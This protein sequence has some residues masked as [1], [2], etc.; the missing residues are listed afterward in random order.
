MTQKQFIGSE[1]Q[2][3]YNE[4]KVVIL[5]IPYEKTTT[6]R[7]GCQN[8]AAAIIEASDQLEAYDIELGREICQEMGIFTH[9]AI[10]DTRINP[11][12]TPEA[13]IEITT[14]TVSKLIADRKFV[15][16]LGGEHSI[17]GAVVKAYKQALG[18]E[19]FT[20]IQI[21]AHGDMRHSYE[22]SIYNHACVMR[23]VL[24]MGLPTL[25]IGIR[26]ICQE[27]AQLI[28]EKQIPVIWAT[29]IYRQSNWS[30]RALSQITT[31]KVFITIDLDGLDP[32]LMPGVGTPEPGGL[33][34]YELT[35]FLTRVFAEYQ[36]IGC[37]VMELAPSSDSVVSEF[38]AA[39]L[40]Y[41]LIGYQSNF[42]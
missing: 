22:G 31:K 36:V 34:W 39:K 4:A 14:N 37:D 30:D 27:E 8:G 29:D 15:I 42:A 26:S 12:L 40:V 38:T 13:M 18:E 23:R 35:Q 41:K 7:K 6:Y 24:D 33:N 5:P 16:A 20:V 32:N 19:L 3:T 10:A 1:A 9:N 28:K 21:D 11:D 25:P 17:T 2:T